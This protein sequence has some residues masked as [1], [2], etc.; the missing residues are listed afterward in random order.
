MSQ[1]SI[2]RNLFLFSWFV[3]LIGN[4]CLSH[5]VEQNLDVQTN[6]NICIPGGMHIKSV[7]W[8][9]NN[10]QL[11]VAAQKNYFLSMKVHI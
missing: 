9:K 10:K 6:K 7:A 5:G 3:E 11:P 8:Q 4:H 2:P 1:Q